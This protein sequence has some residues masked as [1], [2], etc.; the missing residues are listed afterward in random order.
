MHFVS[1]LF[2]RLSVTSG[3]RLCLTAQFLSGEM[4]G[5]PKANMYWTPRKFYRYIV[6][7]YRLRLVGWPQVMPFT[8]LSNI[9]G[10]MTTAFG[11]LLKM[12]DQ[13]TLRFERI[14]EAE[15]S[16]LNETSAAPGISPPPKPWPGR[17]DVKKDRHR[18]VTN[19]LGLPR[20]RVNGGPKTPP[21]VDEIVDYPERISRYVHVVDGSERASK[22]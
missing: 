12:W 9:R 10:R 7:P 14:T 15:F 13:G 5:N 1:T 20:R 6:K 16:T 22:G 17:C 11:L 21:F 18:P 4:S 8:N 19:L 2:T 3:P